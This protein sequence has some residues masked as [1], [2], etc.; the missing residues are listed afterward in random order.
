MVLGT[1]AGCLEDVFELVEVVVH[2]S[3]DCPP[4]ERAQQG[5]DTVQLDARVEMDDRLATAE[6]NP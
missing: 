3:L 4:G 1:R 5:R 2:S 6:A